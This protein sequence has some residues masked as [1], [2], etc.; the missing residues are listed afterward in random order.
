VVHMQGKVASMHVSKTILPSKVMQRMPIEPQ[1]EIEQAHHSSIGDY[2]RIARIDHWFKNIFIFPGVAVAIYFTRTAPGDILL[3]LLLGFLSVCLV[4]SA[5]YVINEWLDRE[6][7]QHHPSKQSRPA[8][9]G[10]I[11]GQGVLIEYILL[12]AAGLGLAY[13]ISA[14]FLVF[15]VALLVMGI[16]YN[17]QPFR[18]KDRVYLDVLSESV[19][20]PLRFML[21]WSIVV[22]GVLPPSS[23]LLAYWMGGAFLMAIKRFAEYRFIGDHNKAGLYRR[24]FIYYTEEKLLISSFFYALTS[25]FF[26]GIFLVK[27]RIEFLVSFPLFALLFA[28]YLDIGLREHSPTQNP[29]KLYQEVGLVAFLVFLIIVVTGLFFIDLPFLQFFLNQVTY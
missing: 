29:E 8:A 14:E 15:S 7:D 19:N 24:S 10:Q 16:L 21:G 4:A 22:T 6:F 13:T 3:P 26:L 1:K 11:K 28:W 9:Q 20:N 23:I 2:I 5:N 18:T 17:V 27:Y 25:V 12:V